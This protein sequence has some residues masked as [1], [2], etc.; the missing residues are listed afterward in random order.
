MPISALF[1]SYSEGS[2]GEEAKAFVD[3]LSDAGFTLWQVLPFCVPDAC[4]SPY[5][6]YSTFGFNPYFVD[7]PDLCRRGFL[8][9]EELRAARQKVPY[10]CE[11]D[12]LDKER[13]QLLAAAS[14]RCG[15]D[16]HIDKFLR[17]H[18]YT[19]DFC[20]FMGM[21]EAHGD[22]P[23]TSWE[24]RREDGEVSAVWAF[25]QWM[26]YTQWQIVRAYAR[27]KGVKIIGDMPI[28]VAHD[29]ADVFFHRDE[30]LLDGEGMPTKVAGVPPDYFSAEG[31]LWG[32]P[33]YDYAH[34]KENGYAFFRDRVR[35]MTELFDG[36]R[37]DH[38]RGIESYF[39]IPAGAKTARAGAWEPGPGMDLIRAMKD[40]AGDAL[41]IAEDLGDVTEEV[42]RLRRESGFPGMRVLQFAFLGDPDS[43]HLP[44]NYEENC[45]A[46]TGTHDNNT[47]LGYVW[48]LDEGTRRRLLEYCGFEGADFDRGYDA[49]L[50]TMFQ[51]HASRLIL[52]VQD[53]LLFGCDT[54]FNTPG[55]SEGNWA[56]RITSE[57]FD[58]LDR[59]KFRR[60]N[61][62]YG[63]G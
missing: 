9:Q 60:L 56:F 25:I 31:Q 47:L 48:A 37:I 45:V 21:R 36:V 8:T 10:T 58:S 22:A 19:A 29:S 61:D 63:R 11:F 26:A 53:L 42:H 16:P 46:Y 5:K 59:A 2:F 23:W 41:L 34:M 51:S 7:L 15:K 1:G 3:F 49:I 38:F 24:D 6:S 28:Y 14:K 18:P 52:P 44:H 20:R 17:E 57:Q 50:R 54:R 40:A 33:L 32:N 39:A 43:P 62:L 27:E 12:R 35:F 4:G 55:V 13:W 30:F